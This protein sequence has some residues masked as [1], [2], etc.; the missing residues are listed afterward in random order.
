[1]E[2]IAIFILYNCLRA[3]TLRTLTMYKALLPRGELLWKQ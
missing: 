1:M 2:D 3:I